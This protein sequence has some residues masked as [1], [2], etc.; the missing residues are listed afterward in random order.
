MSKVVMLDTGP[1]GMI[2]HPRPAAAVVT[3]FAELAAAGDEIVIPEIA[4]YEVRRELL[5]AG[6]QK[7]VERLDELKASWPP[8]TPGIWRGSWTRNIGKPSNRNTPFVRAIT[9]P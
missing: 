3:W 4:D 7:G 9:Q 5:R 6:K 8:R 2:S 1:L